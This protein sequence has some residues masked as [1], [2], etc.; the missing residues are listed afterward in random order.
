M[1]ASL[2]CLYRLRSLLE[3]LSRVE[4]E[5]C[6]KEAALLEE[7][8]EVLRDEQREA[9]SELA[10]T[11]EIVLAQLAHRRE[12]SIQEA[13]RMAQQSVEQAKSSYLEHRKERQQIESVLGMQRSLDDLV[14]NRREQRWI[15]DWFGQKRRRPK[16]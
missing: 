16:G 10:E 15:D 5:V 13:L 7:T 12:Q 11:K 4:L 8:S 9:F 6:L 3:D 1:K 2:E 14:R